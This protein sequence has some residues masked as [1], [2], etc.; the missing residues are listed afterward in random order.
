MFDAMQSEDLQPRSVDSLVSGNSEETRHSDEPHEIRVERITGRHSLPKTMGALLPRRLT[1]AQ[2]PLDYVSGNRNM[3]ID[4]SIETTTES[5]GISPSLQMSMAYATSTSRPR[6][7]TVGAQTHQ[8]GLVD[9]AKDFARKLRRK[10]RG[11]LS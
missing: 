8:L 4:V 9:R 1:G 2:S 7:A 11:E 3:V 10:S 5:S 6:A